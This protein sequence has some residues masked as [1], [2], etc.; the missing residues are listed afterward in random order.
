MPIIALTADAMQGDREKCLAA[1]MNDYL[2]KPFKVAQL[3][4]MLERW[5]QAAPASSDAV[6]DVVPVSEEAAVDLSVFDMFREAGETGTANAFVVH[7]IDQYLAE[8][9]TRMAAL[10]D[11]VERSDGAAVGIATHSL[12]GMSSTV[13]AGRLA[14]MCQELETLAHGAAFIGTPDHYAALEHELARVRVALLAEQGAA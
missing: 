8:A 6:V 9:A 10:K 11:A 7:L 5:S 2:S 12:K 13:G 14:V 4:E 3:R 1:G